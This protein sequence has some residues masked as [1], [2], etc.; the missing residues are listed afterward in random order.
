LFEDFKDEVLYRVLMVDAYSECSRI[1]I[2]FSSAFEGSF[3]E[4]I[5]V[6]SPGFDEIAEGV[7]TQFIGRSGI[8]IGNGSIS[9]HGISSGMHSVLTFTETEKNTN[10]RDS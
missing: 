7:M 10:R 9:V 6:Y 3:T 8:F 2:E 1:E 5:D 4:D